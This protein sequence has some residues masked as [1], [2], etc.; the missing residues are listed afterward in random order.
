MLGGVI[1]IAI[2][3]FFA[4]LMTR[5]LGDL[6]LGFC[7]PVGQLGGFLVLAVVVGIAG[8]V[9]PARRGARIDVLKALRHE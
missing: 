2:G 9:I 5:A 1:G 6:G 4:W 7:V 3:V 8:A